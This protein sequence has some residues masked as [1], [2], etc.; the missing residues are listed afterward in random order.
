MELRG[1]E[2]VQGIMSRIGSA[3]V[4]CKMSRDAFKRTLVLP[5]QASGT[6]VEGQCPGV[7]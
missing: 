7:A 3:P 5:D 4:D 6:R 1:W 2:K